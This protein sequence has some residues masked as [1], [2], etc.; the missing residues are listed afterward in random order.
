[1]PAGCRAYSACADGAEHQQR[2]MPGNVAYRHTSCL[3]L[4]GSCLKLLALPGSARW[5]S[6]RASMTECCN[7]AKMVRGSSPAIIK[8]GF[9]LGPLELWKNKIC[10]KC[11]KNIKKWKNRCA[12]SCY[13][14]ATALQEADLDVDLGGFH[15]L[16]AHK[17]R[18]CQCHHPQT[19]TGI[20]TLKWLEIPRF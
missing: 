12:S 19:C 5:I 3:W 1:M 20:V 10:F 2:E 7:C 9:I 17:I 18:K 8:T 6:S 16:V 15:C 13:N 11:S 4:S 14:S